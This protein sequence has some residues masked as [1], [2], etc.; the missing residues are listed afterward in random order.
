MN[1]VAIYGSERKGSTYHI[2]Q[3]FLERLRS[4]KDSLTEFFLPKDM[5]HFCVGCCNCF[6]KGEAHCPHHLAV[7]PIREAMR[8]ADL[9]ILSSPVYVLRVSGQMKALLDH[10]A[11][12]FMIH[13]PPE[14][15]FSKTALVVTTG[16]GGG[17]KGVVK[18]IKA[19]LDMWG[20]GRVFSYGKAVS[21]ADWAGVS[22]K[23][24]AEIAK[25]VERLAG[26]IK[27]PAGIIKPRLKVRLLFHVFRAVHRRF[28]FNP[29]DRQH[30][31][32]KGWLDRAKPW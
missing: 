17:M 9:I 4:E 3:M 24:K 13:R 23:K 27:A 22:D 20:I 15:M 6:A 25:S 16:A 8:K 26:K 11:F 32:D 10:F 2:V 31:K 29:A 1:I 14:E 30:W 19:S 5:P 7:A 28:E 18:D 12:Q 21:A